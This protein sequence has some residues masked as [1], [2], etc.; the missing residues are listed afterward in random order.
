[1]SPGSSH[2]R[3]VP[4]NAQGLNTMA[5]AAAPALSVWASHCVLNEL[6]RKEKAARRRGVRRV[7][8]HS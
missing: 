1:M 5:P 7:V 6:R 8:R 3:T 4:Y 2:E